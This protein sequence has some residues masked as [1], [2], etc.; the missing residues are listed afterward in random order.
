MHAL[1]P[2]YF[3]LSIG[4]M[5]VLHLAVPLVRCVP[6]PWNTIGAVPLL[7]GIVMAVIAD[8]LFAR[9]ETTIYPFAE[10]SVLVVEGPFRYTRNPMYLGLILALIGL[11]LL[12]GTLTPWLVIVPFGLILDRTFVR[13]EQRT[14][15]ERF[16]D[17][18]RAYMQR[19]RRWI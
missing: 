13:Y 18:Y 10:P 14:M 16:G 15:Q 3:M 5:I 6:I 9:R 8:R 19:V 11:A 12:L 4:V 2:G 7:G 1:P 17:D